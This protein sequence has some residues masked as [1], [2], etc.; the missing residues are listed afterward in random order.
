MPVTFP[1][2]FVSVASFSVK[3]YVAGMQTEGIENST[4]YGGDSNLIA[5]SFGCRILITTDSNESVQ[6][7]GD[8]SASDTMTSFT[9]SSLSFFITPPLEFCDCL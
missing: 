1:S 4:V 8:S 2:R 5:T 9:R 7:S 3:N 6:Q